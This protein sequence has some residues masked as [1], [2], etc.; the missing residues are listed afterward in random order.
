M[1]VL[2]VI[3][4]EGVHVVCAPLQHPGGGILSWSQVGV[5]LFFRSIGPHHVGHLVNR[6]PSSEKYQFF[7][8]IL[9]F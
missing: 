7:L 5:N 3:C 9:L 8:I 6:N 1:L 4:E 2:I